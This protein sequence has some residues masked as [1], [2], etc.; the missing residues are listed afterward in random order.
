MADRWRAERR[1]RSAVGAEAVDGAITTRRSIRGFLPD[2]VPMETVRHLLALASR[3]PSGSNVQPWKSHVVTGAALQ[4]LK[5]DLFAV[6]D[7]GAPEQREYEYYPRNWRSPY[8][9]RRRKVGWELYRLAGVARGDK[10]AG[11]RQRARNYVFFGAPV[12][13]IFTIDR[14]LEQGSWL[15]Y[16]MFLQSLMIAARGHGLDTCAQAAIASYPAIVTR[17]L[18]IPAEEMVICGMAL[19]WADLGEPTNALE[20]EREPVDGFTAFHDA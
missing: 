3:A 13:L 17:H 14:D 7:S 8:L 15:D 5:D 2:P 11:H 16:G 4:R 18:A 20:S 1:D 12:G 10:E 19:G 9:D 6:F